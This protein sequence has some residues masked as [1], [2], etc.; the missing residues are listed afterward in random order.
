MWQKENFVNYS[1][2]SSCHNVNIQTLYDAFVADDFL[3]HCGKRRTLLFLVIFPVVTMLTFQFLNVSVAL[4]KCL[5]FQNV[6]VL[7]MCHIWLQ[8][9]VCH[10]MWNFGQLNFSA[11]YL[12]QITGVQGGCFSLLS[13]SGC[14]WERVKDKLFTLL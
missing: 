10:A 2:F 6:Y 4:V 7:Y 14:M 8:I 13:T 1:N 12:N 3:K 11:W 5:R 9:C